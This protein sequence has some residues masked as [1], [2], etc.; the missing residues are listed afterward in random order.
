MSQQEY[1]V[2]EHLKTLSKEEQKLELKKFPKLTRM[3]LG[4]LL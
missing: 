4:A 2:L 1:A 3:A